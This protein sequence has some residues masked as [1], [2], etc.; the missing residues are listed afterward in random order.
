MVSAAIKVLKVT[1]HVLIMF[2]AISIHIG[3]YRKLQLKDIP[4]A[5]CRTKFAEGEITP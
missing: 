2:A 3:D 5:I 1:F 4:C